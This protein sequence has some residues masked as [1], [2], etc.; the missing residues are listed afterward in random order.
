MI[1]RS[2]Q[3]LTYVAIAL[4][5]HDA[6]AHGAGPGGNT[7]SP[8]SEQVNTQ[9]PNAVVPLPMS[10]GERVLGTL[11][12]SA[13]WKPG[14]TIKVCFLE[15][16]QA[17]RREISDVISEW[18]PGVNLKIDFG[19]TEIRTCRSGD[20]SDVRVGFSDP[21][22]NYSYSYVGTHSTEQARRGKQ[23]LNLY[24][25]DLSRPPA[26]EFRRI[27]LHESGHLFGLEHEQQNPQHNYC[28]EHFD[29]EK[30][31]TYFGKSG[32]NSSMVEMFITKA[33][34]VST[35]ITSDFDPASIMYYAF[36]RDVFVGGTNEICWK[37]NSQLSDGDRSIVQ[38][39]YPFSNVRPNRLRLLGLTENDVR[40]A[41]T[42]NSGHTDDVIKNLLSD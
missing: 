41:T 40:A 29:V 18:L 12:R 7:G 21:S 31:R 26:S 9:D 38:M 39:A 8:P 27:V 20:D 24:R 2:L 37:Y 30:L 5:S 13:L 23:T 17:L 6:C 16:D 36:V 10:Q 1:R 22:V 34:D 25:F 32:W 15:G 19:Q 3:V 4:A 42:L 35:V 33:F 14:A 28:R 11:E